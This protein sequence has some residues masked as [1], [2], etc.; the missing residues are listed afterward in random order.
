MEM[1][2]SELGCYSDL[3]SDPEADGRARRP[4]S[5]IPFSRG[6]AASENEP[7]RDPEPPRRTRASV[8]VRTAEGVT[9]TKEWPFDRRDSVRR[10]PKRIAQMQ[11][12]LLLLALGADAEMLDRELDLPG[13]EHLKKPSGVVAEAVY[14]YWKMEAKRLRKPESLL[15]QERLSTLGL[16]RLVREW[17]VP[18]SIVRQIL[19]PSRGHTSEGM[20][21]RFLLWAVE[22]SHNAQPQRVGLHSIFSTRFGLN[23]WL[24]C[25]DGIVA[26]QDPA[27]VTMGTPPIPPVVVSHFDASNQWRNPFQDDIDPLRRAFGIAVRALGWRAFFRRRIDENRRVWNGR[28]ARLNR[29]WVSDPD[30]DTKMRLELASTDYVA[31]IATNFEHRNW[32]APL[33]RLEREGGAWLADELKANTARWVALDVL[34]GEDRSMARTRDIPELERLQAELLGP[35]FPAVGLRQLG[36][37]VV[38]A[39]YAHPT[40]LEH[41]QFANPLSV[42]VAYETADGYLLVQER[43]KEKVGYGRADWQTSAAGF[44]ALPRDLVDRHPRESEVS[45]WRTAEHET[46]EELGAPVAPNSVVALGVAREGHS[47]EVGLLCYGRLSGHWSDLTEAIPRDAAG[48]KRLRLDWLETA[49]LESWD[50]RDIVRSIVGPGIDQTTEVRD[51]LVLPISPEPIFRFV[52]LWGGSPNDQGRWGRWMP[53]GAFAVLASL[54]HK[55]GSWDELG[56]PWMAAMRDKGI[57][58]TETPAFESEP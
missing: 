57:P 9:S 14:G 49:R 29:A 35:G 16:D 18:A 52:A 4:K 11:R 41:S 36:A 55:A 28:L 12:L 33:D 5:P 46:A 47:L 44:V 40:D 21:L 53:L 23:G 25:G 56:P 20:L 32:D 2:V 1:S 3:M 30:F 13:I 45:I 8:G 31:T 58:A 34:P 42:N 43:D 38:E 15:I 48:D 24:L 6:L 19:D 54:A 27:T 26:F 50:P 17:G 37:D 10:D 39:E 51:Y 22:Q 7:R